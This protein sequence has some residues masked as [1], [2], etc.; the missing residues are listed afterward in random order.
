M[1]SKAIHTL[2]AEWQR[3]LRVQDWRLELKIV[4][5]VDFGDTTTLGL[6]EAWNA[7][8]SAIIK[9]LDPQDHQETGKL[10][11]SLEVV[12][13]H[14][15]LHLVFPHNGLRIPVNLKDARYCAYEQGIDITARALVDA[16]YG[17]QAR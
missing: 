8:K 16:K 6:C 7:K 4:R 15:L 12:I 5:L 14:E 2:L 11:E 13:V 9:I 1:T 3:R 10:D 17:R